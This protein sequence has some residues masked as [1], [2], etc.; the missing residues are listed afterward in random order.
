MYK[1]LGRFAIQAE[2]SVESTCGWEIWRR[3]VA[4]DSKCKKAPVVL[5]LLDALEKIKSGY[6]NYQSVKEIR[7]TF[8]GN[9]CRCGVERKNVTRG[10]K[11]M[12]VVRVP[13]PVRVRVYQSMPML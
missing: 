4:K 7:I 13:V 11:G 9:V 2:K 10:A 5:S 8:I 1:I 12:L 6:S 3:K